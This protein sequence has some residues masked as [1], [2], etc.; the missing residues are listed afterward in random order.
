[1]KRVTNTLRQMS[2]IAFWKYLGHLAV[3]VPPQLGQWILLFILFFA[4]L[5]LFIIDQFLK[6]IAHLP[7]IRILVH[8]LNPF[9]TKLRI[10]SPEILMRRMEMVRPFKVRR[11]Y[12]IFIA[13]QNLLSRKSRS[14]VT[15]LGMSIGVGV[16]VYLLSL[17]YG[18]ER[19]VISQVASL[20]EL[21]VLDVAAGET[22]TQKINAAV[23][24]KIAKIPTVKQVLPVVSVVGRVNYKNAKI[25]MLVY[26]VSQDYLKAS[27]LNFLKG[28][29]FASANHPTYTMENGQVAGAETE[30]TKVRL[31]TPISEKKTLFNIKPSESAPIWKTCSI[32]STIIGYSSHLEGGYE[33]IEMWGGEYYPFMPYGRQGYD[34]ESRSYAG[35]WI[36]AKVPVYTKNNK[37]VLTPVLDDMG[38]QLYDT[39]CIQ[40]K[41]I[42][43]TDQ[44]TVAEVLGTSTS[45]AQIEYEKDSVVLAASDSATPTYDTTIVA[46]DSSGLEVVKLQADA[47]TTTSTSKDQTLKFQE[48]PSGTAIV[49]SG[50]LKLL[51]IPVNQG[52]NTKFKSSFIIVQ[53]IM[54]Q[55]H[56]RALT[57]E[58]E[59][60]VSGVVDDDDKQY[61]YVPI[62]DMQKL[63]V[64]NFSQLKT[65]L[66]TNDSLPKVRREIE[67]LGFNTSSA[68]DTVAQIESFFANLRLI[69]AL[70]GLIALAVASLGMFNTLT[71][72]LLERTREIGGMKTIGMVSDEIQDLFLAEAMIMGFAGGIGGLMFGYIAGKVTSI[73]ISVIAVAQ[74]IGYLNVT[75]IPTYLI[76]F[77]VVSSFVVG[78]ITGLY[79]AQRARKIS[80]LN[81]LRYE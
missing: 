47:A 7:L 76:I 9:L 5:I 1:M 54:P 42:Y 44:F 36:M 30:F 22:T 62:Q 52:L 14:L 67:T 49:S 80:A 50:F 18:I 24:A 79:P 61:F 81:A 77:I 6:T 35:K 69:L 68:V 66:A 64:T 2:T 32:S 20:D 33:G 46:T 78:V 74:G 10:M 16:I 13:F 17:G 57:D 41:N 53:S 25:D 71:V 3:T 59:Y 51:N 28:T 60:T 15:I 75:Y 40:K 37:D 56:G 8:K 65:V 11:S 58:V 48:T 63:G 4:I 55:V 26:A 23:M 45:S 34:S 19:L 43:I 21:R 73:A 38:R 72:S 12:L 31:Y 27:R 29:F 70:I 39:G